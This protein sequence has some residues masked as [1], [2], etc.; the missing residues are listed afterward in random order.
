MPEGGT[1]SITGENVTLRGGEIAPDLSG[2]FA[3]LIVRDTGTGIPPDILARV[4]DP[5]FTTKG[6]NK[7]TGLGLSQVYGFV[8][9]AGGH[10]AVSSELGNG[11]SFTLYLP[12][13]MATP[14]AAV[15]AA[16][17][18]N[19]PTGISV[20]VVEDNPDVADVAAALLEQLGNR[21][22]VVANAADALE[23]IARGDKPDV[24]FS[25]V[26]M[27]G[28]M[29]GVALGRRVRELYPDVPVLLATGYSQTAERVGD[30]FPI[31]HKPYEMADLN[32]ALGALLAHG[33]PATQTRKLRVVI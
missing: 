26:V 1:V 20:L 14:I 19:A 9:Q 17:A 22:E 28:E 4:F 18:V 5:F 21:V 30:E 24:L 6:V 13:V 2:D 8:R 25:D 16:A 31:L 3:A 7:G 27:A 29:D 15:E 12:R 10:V 32:R 23:L 33:R 11:T